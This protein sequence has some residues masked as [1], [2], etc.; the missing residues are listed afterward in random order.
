V[1]VVKQQQT[2]AVVCSKISRVGGDN[3]FENP[4]GLAGV[5]FRLTVQRRDGEIDLEVEAIGMV[6]GQTAEDLAGL[7]EFE[8]PH[9]P[10]AAVVEGDRVRGQDG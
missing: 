8:L 9:Q 1:A 6:G 7:S 5:A 3:S 2:E 10:N 4:P